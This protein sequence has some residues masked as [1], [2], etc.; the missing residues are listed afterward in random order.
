VQAPLTQAWLVHA[1]AAP[2]VPLVVHVWTPLP[3]QVVWPGPHTP[4]HA[5]PTQ[6]WLLQATI[7]PHVPLD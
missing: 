4:V 2:Q 1:T 7:E 5:P 6:V 3:L